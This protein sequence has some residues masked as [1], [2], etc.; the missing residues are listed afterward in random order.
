[1]SPR[2]EQGDVEELA[3]P[4]VQPLVTEVEMQV[5]MERCAPLRFGNQRPG[6]LG[7]VEQAA[8]DAADQA[9][10]VVGIEADHSALRLDRRAAQEPGSLG[11]QKGT[12]LRSSAL[13]DE[14]AD[15]GGPLESPIDWSGIVFAA[16]NHMGL[17]RDRVV[18]DNVL[19]RLFEQGRGALNGSERVQGGSVGAAPDGCD[20]RAAPATKPPPSQA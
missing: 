12:V 3:D 2:S 4:P 6:L 1:M 17:T 14:R 7:D 20:Q 19:F 15:G 10:V 13:L 8:V 5:A 16:S 11:R 9:R 18:I